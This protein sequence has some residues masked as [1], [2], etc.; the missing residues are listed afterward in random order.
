[1]TLSKDVGDLQ[2]GGKKV[3]LNHLVMTFSMMM[4]FPM[5]HDDLLLT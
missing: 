1:M 3:T 5:T 2:P 4:N